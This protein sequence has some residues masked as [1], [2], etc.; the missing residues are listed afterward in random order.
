[1]LC[2]LSEGFLTIACVLDL[3]VIASSFLLITLLMLGTTYVVYKLGGIR[4]G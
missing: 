2:V 3:Q 1:M 4:V